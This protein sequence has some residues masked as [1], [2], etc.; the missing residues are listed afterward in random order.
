MARDDIDKDWAN[1][2]DLISDSGDS[3]KK[4]LVFGDDEPKSK[5]DE[6]DT[7]EMPREEK[8]RG[9]SRIAKRSV[10]PDEDSSDFLK[11]KKKRKKKPLSLDDV[12]EE[13]F[14]AIDA[15]EDELADIPDEIDDDGEFESDLGLSDKDDDGDDWGVM[16][17]LLDVDDYVDEGDVETDEEFMERQRILR[18]TAQKRQSA[19]G[20]PLRGARSGSKA[21]LAP[22]RDKKAVVVKKPARIAQK[23]SSASSEDVLLGRRTRSASP[24]GAPSSSQLTT[25]EQFYPV[26]MP[27]ETRVI[28]APEGA[29]ERLPLRAREIEREVLIPDETQL[30]METSEMP[31]AIYEPEPHEKEDPKVLQDKL[32]AGFLYGAGQLEKARV[33]VKETEVTAVLTGIRDGRYG[34]KSQRDLIKSLKSPI[35]RFG[36][37]GVD[38]RLGVA[39]EKERRI[40]AY[41]TGAGFAN[42]RE[43]DGVTI[44]EFLKKYPLPQDFD[45][46]SEGFLRVIRKNS[47]DVTYGD[48]VEAME[49]FKW[50]IYGVRQDYF[51]ALK[52]LLRR[53]EEQITTPTGLIE[54]DEAGVKEIISFA[55]AEGD[56][57][58]EGAL[59][60]KLTMPVILRNKLTPKW[61]LE[62]EDSL[63]AFSQVFKMTTRDVVLAYVFVDGV[64]KLRSFYRNAL[65]GVWRYLPD[66][67]MKQTPGGKPEIW[68]GQAYAEEMLILPAA[69]QMRLSE[70]AEKGFSRAI[71]DAPELIFAG[72]A[73]RYGSLK[74]YLETRK[75]ARLAGPMY[76]EVAARPTVVF[77]GLSKVKVRPS[78]VGIS[79]KEKGSQPDFSHVVHEWV[80]PTGLNGKARATTFYSKDGK[81]EY[82][83]YE[84]N[85]HRA[86]LGQVELKS[87]LTSVGLRAEWVYPGDLATPVYERVV[88][89]DGYGDDTD[90]KGG[91]ISMW[92]KYVSKLGIVKDYLRAKLDRK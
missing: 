52:L 25:S 36:E 58:V 9:F 78:E 60:R 2:D 62:L 54:L 22:E 80:T 16:D 37:D 92:S 33:N 24:S 65:D 89:S 21:V 5:W 66:Y 29:E 43:T 6:L 13:D 72:T 63:F 26:K 18:G 38:R 8:R 55:R 88:K 81:L 15:D 70:I 17:D 41:H 75:L 59:E 30:P 49:N 3:E 39:A 20:Q 44:K 84:D 77:G 57:W 42:W 82:V 71:V 51:E 76:A 83:F 86:W 28:A 31:E 35:E 69:L 46:A 74:E 48:Y 50:Q 64:W 47:G 7:P 91:Y 27:K 34:R 56:A 79:E 40:L 73:L 4:G 85:R 1:L 53:S 14:D 90:Q 45:A 11:K 32:V 67:A 87:D 61:K 19:S 23:Q 10:D 68:C 12:E